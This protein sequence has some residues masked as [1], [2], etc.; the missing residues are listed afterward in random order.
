[1]TRVLCISGNMISSIIYVPHGLYHVHCLSQ[2]ETVGI[3]DSNS[4]QVLQQVSRN[5][6]SNVV[7]GGQSRNTQIPMLARPW[8]EVD[9]QGRLHGEDIMTRRVAMVWAQPL[10]YSCA[11]VSS[12]W[13]HIVF[14]RRTVT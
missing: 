1:V 8:V 10:L 12:G 2:W 3:W 6:R 13:K 7:Q 14:N 5:A 9:T 4:P 11:V